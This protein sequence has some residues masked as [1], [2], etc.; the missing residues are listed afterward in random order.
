MNVQSDEWRTDTQVFHWRWW[1]SKDN[2]RYINYFLL[3]V[4]YILLIQN[5][6]RPMK[7]IELFVDN[8]IRRKLSEK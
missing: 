4:N 2:N 7:I 8:K 1:P 6:N 3:V 5:L